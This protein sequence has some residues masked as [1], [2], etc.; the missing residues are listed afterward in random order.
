MTQ[1]ESKHTMPRNHTVCVPAEVLP[2]LLFYT[3]T[4]VQCI[5][6]V[7]TR[8]ACNTCIDWPLTDHTQDSAVV[9][10]P[11]RARHCC[12]DHFIHII[13]KMPDLHTF[14]I[15]QHPHHTSSPKFDRHMLHSTLKTSCPTG[16]LTRLP[17]QPWISHSTCHSILASQ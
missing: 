10:A 5:A 14:M 15:A 8:Q 11:Q 12:A 13:M 9:A 1:P 16:T 6:W 4:G 7:C 2:Q 17:S 3:C